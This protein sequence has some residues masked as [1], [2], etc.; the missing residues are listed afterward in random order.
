ML[1]PCRAGADD[2]GR[3]PLNSDAISNMPSHRSPYSSDRSAGPGAYGPRLCAYM[4]LRGNRYLALPEDEAAFAVTRVTGR[5][6]L[7]A[8]SCEIPPERAYLVTLHLVPTYLE[9]GPPD[10]ARQGYSCNAG[11]IGIDSLLAPLIMRARAP[12]DCLSFYIRYDLLDELAELPG[13]MRSHALRCVH[14]VPDPVLRDIGM[15]LMPLLAAPERI[16]PEFLD[17]I[18]RAACLHL[19][20][21]YGGASRSGL[22]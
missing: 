15:A 12:L 21:K 4:G 16:A 1:A 8:S 5:L 6:D 20:D 13:A 10:G 9:I 18:A 17:H 7:M 3:A 2:A 11:S 22:S 19:M 14:G